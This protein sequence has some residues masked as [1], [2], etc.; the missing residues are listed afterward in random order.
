MRKNE[1]PN[2][3]SEP[4]QASVYTPLLSVSFLTWILDFGFEWPVK[5][6]KQFTMTTVKSLVL[7]FHNWAP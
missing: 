6:T 3:Y 5:L 4:R 7:T 2:R 1:R